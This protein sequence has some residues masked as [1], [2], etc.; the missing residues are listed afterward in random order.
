MITAEDDMQRTDL[1]VGRA[2]QRAW[3]ALTKQGLAVQPMM[4]LLVLQN[5]LEHGPS[6]LRQSLGTEKVVSLG[7]EFRDLVSYSLARLSPNFSCRIT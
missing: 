5:A 6:P 3:L 1:L 4:S 7:K 2:M